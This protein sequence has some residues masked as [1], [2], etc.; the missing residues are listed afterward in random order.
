MGNEHLYLKYF[1]I[2]GKIALRTLLWEPPSMLSY[3][4]A[5]FTLDPLG[6]GCQ[7]AAFL[8]AQRRSK[9]HQKCPWNC[10]YFLGSHSR[11][12]MLIIPIFFF[13]G[14]ELDIAISQKV[15]LLTDPM[16]SALFFPSSDLNKIINL[17][18]SGNVAWQLKRGGLIS[19]CCKMNDHTNNGWKQHTLTLIFLDQESGHSSLD[20]LL[21]ILWGCNEGVGQTAFSPRGSA[22]ER[23]SSKISAVVRKIQL[24]AIVRL[25]SEFSSW[26]LPPFLGA[27]QSLAPQL[28][29][30]PFYNVT[31]HIFKTRGEETALLIK[32]GPI[33]LSAFSWLS[34]AF[35]RWHLFN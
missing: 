6:K 1:I 22:W 28:S 2:T 3:R 21:R 26:L 12:D 7:R 34:Q 4:N 27:S 32:D 19:R 35:P 29:L 18:M 14:G 30:L 15:L 11:A 20:Y 8:L 9:W 16:S 17:L 25:M 23:L 10:K 13:W 5:F 33:L 31:A 24:P